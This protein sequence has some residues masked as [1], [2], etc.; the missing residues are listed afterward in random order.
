[1]KKYFLT[2]LM[3]LLC[4]FGLSAQEPEDVTSA[5]VNP[6]FE[7]GI[8]GWLNNGMQTQSNTAFALKQGNIYVEKWIARGSK[9]GDGSVSQTL[10]NMAAGQYVLKAKAQNVQEDSPSVQRRGAYLF[11]GENRKEVGKTGE[12]ELAFTNIYADITLGF[13]MEGATGN[14]VA[15]DDF[16]LYF[17]GCDLTALQAELGARIEE[18]ETLL[19]KKMQ[20]AAKTELE[21]TLQ[22]AR[23]VREKDTDAARYPQ[24][25]GELRQ[26]AALAGQFV[27]AYEA[28]ATKIAECEAIY[29]KGDPEKGEAYLSSIEEAKKV[30]DDLDATL[31]ELAR[32]VKLLDAATFAYRVNNGTGT[33][34]TVVTQRRYVRGS[35]EGF[36]RST[37]KGVSTSLLLEEGYCWSETNPEPTVLDNR[38]TSYLERNGKAYRVPMEPGRLYYVRA[39]AMTKN[40]AVGYGEVMRV[41]SLP[42]GS[43]TWTYNYGGDEAQNNRISSAL[44]EACDY[45]SNY[46]SIRGFN[47]SCTYSPGTPTAD[48]GY[49]GGMRMGTNMGQ[50]A[51]TCMHEMSHGIGTGTIQEI[52]GGDR[53]T[54][55]RKEPNGDWMGDRANEVIR[56]W[57]NNENVVVTGAYDN[58]H[59]GIRELNGAYEEGGSAHGVWCNKYAFN[60]A[61]L[62]PYA[63]AGAQNWNDLQINFIAN[64]MLNQAFCE[65]GLVP[66]NFWGGAFCLPAYVFEQRDDVKYYIKNEDEARG[67]Y[68]SFL[69]ET[70]TGTLK[71]TEIGTDE[72]ADNDEAAWYVT[73]DPETQYYMLQNAATGHYISYISN[74][75]KAKAVS[76]PTER[77]RFHFMQRRKADCQ[78]EDEPRGYWMIHPTARVCLAANAN[79]NTVAA[80]LNQFDNATN[81]RWL[82]LTAEEVKTTEDRNAKAKQD[83]LKALIANLRKVVAT[84]HVA[85]EDVEEDADSRI[86]STL[87]EMEL[88][89][90]DNN[91]AA[92]LS[93]MVA[94]TREA[95][96]EFLRSVS[97]LS[98]DEPFD[99]T[100]LIKNA[101]T[102]DYVGWSATPTINHS[103]AEFFEKTFDYSQTLTKMPRGTYKL[104]VQAFERP[105]AYAEA[106]KDFAA[107]N[108]KVGT[109]LYMAGRSTKVKHIAEEAQK[110]KLGGGEVSVGSPVRYIP[111]DMYSASI[112]F[113]KGL[114][115]NEVVYHLSSKSA[116]IKIGLRCSNAGTAHWTIFDN[117][118]LYYYGKYTLNDITP[119]EDIGE[120]TDM[121]IEH[122]TVFDLS[123]RRVDAEKMER[124]FYIVNGKKVLKK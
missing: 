3:G 23:E 45:W 44:S 2:L 28:L 57:E 85:N 53:V 84:P 119:V 20:Q 51:G 49:G 30:C 100:F 22:Q 24:A 121:A 14:W 107:G 68:T 122:P 87:N 34:P 6:S 58:G 103:C 111:N 55:L 31:D 120:D 65:D 36:F 116:S 12:Y 61:H 91:D 38:T 76:Q 66:V 90:E 59:W 19:A 39:Y 88:L 43:V 46:T 108:N 21:R 15:C 52:W 32:Q 47:V 89:L 96:M 101:S 37:V 77:E 94:D 9:V 16:R 105:G 98:M 99:L 86:N 79:G 41:A 102:D 7:D 18:A 64:S 25:A 82:I 72:L 113:G 71:W 92:L 60:G 118:R 117:F 10:P 78:A 69:T 42:K 35:I 1:M 11:A 29:A 54:F 17:V 80:T 93:N 81:Q 124:G 26:A 48:C 112:Y 13:V 75:Y 95:G 67:L 40:Y 8:N 62:E 114:Y 104:M 123:G 73:F 97:P 110:K 4:A 109:T 56:F 33:A 63:W 106:Y 70:S 5:I 50:R 83:E 115:D 74:A 27:E